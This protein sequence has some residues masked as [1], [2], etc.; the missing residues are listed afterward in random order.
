MLNG[1][2]GPVDPTVHFTSTTQTMVFE[3]V[4][5]DHTCANIVARKKRLLSGEKFNSGGPII[6]I[7]NC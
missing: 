1:A 3:L 7:S 4:H 5:V 2:L 6:S